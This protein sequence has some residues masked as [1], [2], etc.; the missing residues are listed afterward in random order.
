MDEVEQKVQRFALGLRHVRRH[1]GDPS[2]RTLSNKMNYS[3]STVSRMLNGQIF[4]RWETVEQFLRACKVNENALD[5]RWRTR[6]LEI[7]ELISPI[8]ETV[9]YEDDDEF[10][11]ATEPPTRP[12]MECPQCGALI[13]NPLRH[14]AWHA[15]LARG[16][17][18]QRPSAT[19]QHQ[20][21]LRRASG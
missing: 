15:A 5:G 6:W 3:Y 20:Q 10:A 1:A 16:R 9:P 4:P 8:G 13:V 11:D 19:G 14:Q 18:P 12:T 2:Y 17:G 7:A 21:G